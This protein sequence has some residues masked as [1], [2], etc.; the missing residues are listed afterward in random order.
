[1]TI[2]QLVSL[3]K[4]S[5]R[6]IVLIVSIAAVYLQQKVFVDV[7]FLFEQHGQS[8]ADGQSGGAV[9]GD[10]EVD[11]T[12]QQTGVDRVAHDFVQAVSLER[13]IRHWGWP[14]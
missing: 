13:A 3:G 1:M 6:P 11:S 12:Q 9:C 10:G 4:D 5:V 7:Y 14:N 2:I 8:E